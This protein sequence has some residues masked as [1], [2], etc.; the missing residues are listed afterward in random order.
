MV[1]GVECRVSDEEWQ[2]PR[3]HGTLELAGVVCV[4][5]RDVFLSITPQSIRG[6]RAALRYAQPDARREVL[7]FDADGVA[8]DPIAVASSAARTLAHLRRDSRRDAVEECPAGTQQLDPPLD[9]RLAQRPL[10]GR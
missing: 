6:Q 2:S 5:R 8:D 3:P 4:H 10:L 7:T 1:E 9:F